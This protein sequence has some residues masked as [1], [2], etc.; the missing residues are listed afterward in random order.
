MDNFRR[1]LRKMRMVRC[2]NLNISK[3]SLS[4]EDALKATWHS[5]TPPI[6]PLSHDRLYY[7]LPVWDDKPSLHIQALQP[8]HRRRMYAANTLSKIADKL[9]R[10]RTGK[11]KL[12]EFPFRMKICT[13][14]TVWLKLTM[15]IQISMKL[16]NNF[17]KVAGYV[18]IIMRIYE[19]F[20][21]LF[22]LCYALQHTQHRAVHDRQDQAG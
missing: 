21:R 6:K 13:M 3:N 5:T 20:Q 4:D 17:T 22:Y 14:F 10:N 9:V 2:Q 16:L 1:W 15:I 11:D 12:M 19:Y 18:C 7:F 8:D